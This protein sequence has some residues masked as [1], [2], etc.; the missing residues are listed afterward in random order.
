MRIAIATK[1]LNGLDDSISEV[2]GRSPTFTIIN[3]EN[4]T[5]ESIYP[6][7]NKSASVE[8]GAGPLTCTRLIKLGVNVV[9]A[10]EF[11][12]TVSS[13]LKES[14][15]KEIKVK[16]GTKVEDVLQSYLKITQQ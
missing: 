4:N 6:E 1:G 15:I 3:I 8:H 14:G 7:N 9:V 2:F 10:A 16:V 13:M 11:G 5:I 12:P